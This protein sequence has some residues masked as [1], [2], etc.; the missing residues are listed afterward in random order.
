M[1]DLG[2]DEVGELWVRS[3]GNALGYHKLPEVT[4]ARFDADGWLRTGDLMKADRDGYYFFLGR[5][6]DMINCGGENVYPKE[7]ETILI[8][9][10]NVADA[11]V[12]SA[13]HEM[14]GEAPVV[15]VVPRDPAAA[16]ADE[17]KQ[18]F[19]ANG[20]AYAHPRTITFV[21]KLPLTGAGK[22]D[23]AALTRQAREASTGAASS[24]V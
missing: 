16:D 2:P 17:I 18:F 1:T 5:R 10:P 22:L 4:A 19:F 6:D 7:V 14:K 23:R 20:P 15:F 21:E 8:Q 13:P 11:C 3:P 12:V 9:H 24:S